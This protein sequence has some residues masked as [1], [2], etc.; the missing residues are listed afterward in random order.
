MKDRLGNALGL[1]R[2]EC[3]A[4]LFKILVGNKSDLEAQRA[5][6]KAQAR[7]LQQETGMNYYIEMSA[8]KNINTEHVLERVV[9]SLKK[10]G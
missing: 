9:L 2:E 1:L 7:A 6:S 4:T 10:A 5:I 8:A 3:E